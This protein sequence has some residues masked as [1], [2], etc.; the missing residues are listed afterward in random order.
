[1][2][3][4]SSWENILI[5]SFKKCGIINIIDGN[6]DDIFFDDNNIGSNNEMTDYFQ[7]KSESN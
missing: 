6:E 5:K 2:Q 7:S 4:K 1:M 3:V